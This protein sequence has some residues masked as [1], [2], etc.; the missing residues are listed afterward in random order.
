MKLSKVIISNFKNLENYTLET[1]AQNF[2]LL[3]KNGYGKSSLADAISWVMTGKLLS[4]S[5]DI[6][7]IK[8]KSDTSKLVEVE[9]LFD[10]GTS[11]KK[12]YQ[13]KWVRT[14]G[15]VNKTLS[16]HKTNCY[17]NG[18]ASP[19]TK[20][21][22]ELQSLFNIEFKGKWSG[23]LFQ[24][25]LDPLYFGGKEE[26]QNRRKLV[27]D[28]VGDV[29]DGD[30]FGRDKN[31]LP[32]QKYLQ[33]ANG[34]FES[35]KKV[36]NTNLKKLNEQE[37]TLFAQI[38]VL[39]KNQTVTEE[40]HKDTKK[41]LL[42]IDTKIDELKSQKYQN[43]KDQNADKNNKLAELKTKYNQAQ[44]LDFKAHNQSFSER[45]NEL[46]GVRKDSWDTQNELTSLNRRISEQKDKKAEV[47]RQISDM[48]NRIQNLQNNQKDL[49][50]EWDKL[51]EQKFHTYDHL[52]CPS[53]GFDLNQ[54][55][56]VEQEQAFNLDIANRKKAINQNG[57]E[58][59][60]EIERLQTVMEIERSR[61]VAID[62]KVKELEASTTIYVE[63]INKL[64]SKEQQLSQSIPEFEVSE[65]TKVLTTEITQ[66]QNKSIN[67]EFDSSK[68][69]ILI[70]S[71]L[72]LQ[73]VIDT[74]NVEQ[75]NL[76]HAETLEK[77]QESVLNEIARFENLNALLSEF[78]KTKLEIL[79]GR[80]KTVFGDIKF[81]LVDTNIK[82]G[83]WN[84]VCYVLDDDVPYHNTNSASKLRLGIKVC[85]A[86]KTH[87][88]LSG[89]F[90]LIDNAEQITD[91]DFNKLTTTQTISFVA[92]EV[93][94]E[95]ALQQN[96][97][98]I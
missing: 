8:P 19:V 13:E 12:T 77:E 86:I 14:Q 67:I 30:V 7:S 79:D 24:L 47:E 36:L 1:D 23:N 69:Q 34:K 56:V 33:Q 88:G 57:G 5:S 21:D 48:A 85:E 83:S 39:S 4:G 22:N 78:I 82:E 66:M 95:K 44:E 16:S 59:K 43:E 11:L 46:V 42:A 84:E 17:I 74:G 18:V 45:N 25:L 29:T 52:N 3:A 20:F 71:K 89:L 54:D 6:M 35:V 40:Q 94:S 65:N 32:L 58:T 15:T 98:N 10:S 70:D 50:V 76:K 73:Q 92:N 97:F 75:T 37:K 68:I 80:I 63:T 93:E 87:L 91:R 2:E 96:L 41:Q 51:K 49:R 27:I 62:E 64:K 26:W 31:L 55:K 53:C 61:V 60:G 28:I 38:D 81:R 9:L 72:P 90:Y